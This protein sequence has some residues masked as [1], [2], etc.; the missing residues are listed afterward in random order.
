MKIASVTI[1]S[2][3]YFG[4]AITLANSLNQNFSQSDVYILIVDK[5]TSESLLLVENYDVN[6]IWAEDLCLLNFEKIAFKYNILELNTA[7]KPTFL[8][9]ILYKGLR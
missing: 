1:V 6:I 9:Y 4:Y 2:L 7:L 3:N 5:K 8:K